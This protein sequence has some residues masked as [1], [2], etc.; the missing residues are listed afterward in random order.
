MITLG[1]T[2]G[3]G[4]GKTTACRELENLGASVFYADEE[5][6]RLMV[7]DAE[8][9]RAIAE[10]FGENTYREDGNLNRSY[11]ADRVFEDEEELSAL[12]ELVH[13]RVREAFEARRRAEAEAGTDLLVEEAALIFETGADR[14]LDAVLVVDAPEEVRIARVVE[15]DDVTPSAVRARM[16][17]QWPTE[18]LR[19]R[20]DYVIEN[21]GTEEELRAKVRELYRELIR[22]AR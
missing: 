16:E 5:A 15:R 13:E 12:N 2:G 20:A 7:E 4:S 18:K 3:M 14:L 8:L 17:Y 10:R 11:L 21:T 1:V 9:R 19:S 22:S 6:K